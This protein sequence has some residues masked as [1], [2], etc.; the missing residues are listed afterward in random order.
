V[1]TADSAWA[2]HFLEREAGTVVGEDSQTGSISVFDQ[3]ATSG[4]LP[5]SLNEGEVSAGFPPDVN[6]DINALQPPS[7]I[8][9]SSLLQTSASSQSPQRPITLRAATGV[10]LNGAQLP[11]QDILYI[12][13]DL[14]FKHVNT[15]CPILERKTTFA[16]LFGS[17]SLSET[18]N[19]LMHAIVTVALRFSNDERLTPESKR[20]FHRVSRERVMEHVVSNASVD[21]LK[22]AIILYLDEFGSSTGPTC[23]NMLAVLVQSVT[24]LG[25]S[26]ER[27]A[28]LKVQDCQSPPL[29]FCGHVM[30]H[31]PENWIDDEGRRRLFWASYMLDRYTAIAGTSSTVLLDDVS[32]N[33]F[34]P[35]SYDLF[36]RNVPVMTRLSW[37]Q[38]EP[39]QALIREESL[40]SFSYHC[41][42]LR[43]MSRIHTFLQQPPPETSNEELVYEWNAT[44]QSLDR[45]LDDWLQSLPGEYSKISGLC[46]SDPASRV[47]NWFMLHS[48]FVTAVLR[49][50]SASAYAAPSSSSSSSRGPDEMPP[51]RR[52]TPAQHYA[53]QRCLSAVRSL[54]DITR[55]LLD[56][57]GLNLLG[58]PF[59]LSLWMAARCL[60]VH[61]AAAAPG[62][63]EAD[64]M[65]N[66]FAGTL[67]IMGQYWELAGRHADMLVRVVQTAREGKLSFA[68][69]RR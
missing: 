11:P 23:R 45:A 50:H 3:P 6:R 2:V 27:S 8:S 15:W 36:S 56:A 32:V 48:A 41:D 61:A 29:E 59:T 7:S 49:L 26:S 62:G 24:L 25:L 46:H 21:A 12:L 65:V 20:H 33:R 9:I 39:Q 69:M 55:D 60:L 35:C 38:D 34:L 4:W 51:C 44:Y 14:Y 63:G 53:A 18:D 40:G 43:I 5:G 31:E 54:A 10:V 28:Y 68:D 22:S 1:S 37:Q 67:R 19:I 47:A 52:Q 13:V 30:I 58:P 64:P 66:F 42:V 57:D 17:T 16:T